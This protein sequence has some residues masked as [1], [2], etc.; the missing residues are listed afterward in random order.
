MSAQLTLEALSYL[1]YRVLD[2]PNGTAALGVL[3]AHPEVLLLF[4][5]VGLPGGSTGASSPTEAQRRRPH[6]KVLFT[7]GYARNAIV[8]HGILDVGVE[9]LAKPYTSESLASKLQQ[10]LRGA[11]ESAGTI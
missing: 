3:D 9:L 6:L 4:T 7:T 5:D 10:I 11:P 1:G 2:A 8:H